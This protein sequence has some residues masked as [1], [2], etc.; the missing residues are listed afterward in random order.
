[1]AASGG[2]WL[3]LAAA[4]KLTNNVLIPGIIEEDVRRGGMLGRLPVFQQFGTEITWNREAV[5]GA[6]SDAAVGSQ[7][8]WSEDS[9]YTQVSRALK[10]S[11]RQTVL[12]QFVEDV[13]GNFNNYRNVQGMEDRKALMYH[14]EDRIIYGDTTYG[15]ANQIDGIH[16]LAEAYGQ[17][18]NQDTDVLNID[19][20][21][22][23]LSLANLRQLEDNM[24]YGIDFFLF[25]KEIATRL[26]AYVQEAGLSTNLFGQVNF[27]V[28]EVG[29]R[30]TQWNGIPIIRSDFLVAEQANTGVG[31]DARAKHSS[32]DKQYSIFAI[33]MGQVMRNE[34]GLSIGFGGRDVSPGELIK[35]R[36]FPDLEDFDASGLRQVSYYNL[37][38]GSSMAIGRIYDIE[39]SAVVA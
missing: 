17:G 29:R 21:E 27:T 11:Y 7:L 39:N 22:A 28:D 10:I 33:K 6:A 26:D 34:P 19:E 18:L 35:T 20:G 14:M 31:S 37:A 12:D 13:Y 15:D 9:D 4:Q 30:V 32:G 25:P 36:F 3:D 23:G 24:D 38:D 16:A 1:M 2:H 8:V 5:I